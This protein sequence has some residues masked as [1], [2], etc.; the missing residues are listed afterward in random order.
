MEIKEIKEEDESG[1]EDMI[2]GLMDTGIGSIA[3]EVS[4]ECRYGR[5]CLV[6]RDENRNPMDIISN[7]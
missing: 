6:Q 3:K 4:R 2:G 7:M 5:R 1:L